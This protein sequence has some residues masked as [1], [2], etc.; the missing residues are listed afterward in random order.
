[1]V[2]TRRIEKEKLKSKI[3]KCSVKLNRLNVENKT[4][5]KALFR[6]YG[7]RCLRV[8]VNR[9]IFEAETS[10]T[11]KLKLLP[12][13]NVKSVRC[14]VPW[15][16]KTSNLKSNVANMET[17]KTP[18]SKQLASKRGVALSL[19]HD[20][21]CENIVKSDTIRDDHEASTSK[22]GEYIIYIHI[23]PYVRVIRIFLI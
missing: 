4:F 7:V 20:R 15:L 5:R 22:R 12:A 18:M 16:P 19:N 3:R 8:Q 2:T 9:I 1:M 11:P 13:P 10:P 14:L 17:K 23:D 6:M 21:S